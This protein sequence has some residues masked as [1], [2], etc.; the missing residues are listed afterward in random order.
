MKNQY[1][2]KIIV[3]TWSLSGDFGKVSKKNIYQVFENSVK[4]N[5]LDFDTAPTYGKGKMHKILSEMFKNNKKIKINTKCGYDSNYVKT[6]SIPDVEKSIDKSLNEFGRIN[7]LF[8]HN[9]R[10]EISDW[11][12]IFT[13]LAKYKKNGD[14]LKI[15]ISFARVFYFSEKIINCFDYMQD[16]VNLLRPNNLNFLS[17][18]KPK[19]MVRSPLASGCLAGKF[20]INTK[21]SKN[22][23]RYQWLN[24]QKRLRNILLQ[25][26]EIKKITGINLR[27]FSK[28]FLLQNNNIDHVIFGLKNNPHIEELIYEIKNFKKI[29]KKKIKE[30]HDLALLKLNLSSDKRGY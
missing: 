4:N 5:L 30:I 16:E 11:S 7:T 6:F 15:G 21:F 17:N 2:K 22:D 24:N 20:N 19:L 23:Y 13:L 18:L 28:F 25:I 26:N 12:K 14:I 3:G 1:F 8:L 9:P 10:N 27:T 29:P